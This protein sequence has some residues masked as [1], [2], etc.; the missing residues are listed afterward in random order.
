[1]FHPLDPFC[2]SFFPAKATLFTTRPAGYADG[3]SLFLFSRAGQPR[4]GGRQVGRPMRTR[5]ADRGL[6]EGNVEAFFSAGTGHI[7]RDGEKIED[8]TKPVLEPDQGM[9]VENNRRGQRRRCGIR[10]L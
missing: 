7:G 9:A 6:S 5:L 1:M 2:L 8:G 3:E 10:Q 4:R